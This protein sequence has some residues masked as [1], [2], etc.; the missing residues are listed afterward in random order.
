[1]IC[2]ITSSQYIFRFCFRLYLLSP[3]PTSPPS[4]LVHKYGSTYRFFLQ[5][6]I[7]CWTSSWIYLNIYLRQVTSSSMFSCSSIC[8]H[9][10]WP[11][12]WSCTGLSRWVVLAHFKLMCGDFVCPPLGATK[13]TPPFHCFDGVHR[14][15]DLCR[16]N[17]C[18]RSALKVWWIFTFRQRHL[19]AD[20]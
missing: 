17:Y 3:C 14:N 8:W 16:L 11:R 5:V 19:L 13:Q 20:G 9:K 4:V 1:M 7:P 6:S 18:F 10:S 2:R 15:C 12:Y